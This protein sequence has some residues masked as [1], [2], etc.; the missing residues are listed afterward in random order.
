MATKQYFGA[1]AV[2]CASCHELPELQ[3]SM[4][5]CSSEVCFLRA[6]VGWSPIGAWN[7]LMVEVSDKTTEER[8]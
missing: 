7:E 8:A 3:G 4:V 5:R 1:A 6:L 2:V